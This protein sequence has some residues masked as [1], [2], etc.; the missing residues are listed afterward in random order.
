MKS[1]QRAVSRRLAWPRLGEA[2]V[3]MDH[4]T[5]QNAALVEEM[6]G[7]ASSLKAQAQELVQTVAV[8]NLGGGHHASMLAPAAKVRSTSKTS[9]PFKGKEKREGGI[10]KGAAAR[11]APQP[12]AAT[13]PRLMK[14]APALASSTSGDENWTSFSKVIPTKTESPP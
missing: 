1:V 11:H 7:C 4:T 12:N 3:Q 5:Q 9:A 2:V 10:P 8:F 13:T 6:A 14:P